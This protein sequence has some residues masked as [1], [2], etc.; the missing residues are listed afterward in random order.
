[1]P[2]GNTEGL[3]LQIKVQS[4]ESVTKHSIVDGSQPKR[5]F[6]LI[7]RVKPSTSVPIRQR[8]N[9]DR[10]SKLYGVFQLLLDIRDARS[11]KGASRELVMTLALRSDPTKKYVAW[12]SYA[13]LAEDTQLD[14]VT[15]Q[16]AAKSWS[17]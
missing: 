11:T 13:R 17:G 5:K 7:F 14:P 4:R 10:K 1:M 2:L 12:P 9:M 3:F 8:G 16:R 6:L 15:L